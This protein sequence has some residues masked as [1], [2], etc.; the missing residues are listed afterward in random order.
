MRNKIRVGRICWRLRK[1]QHFGAE[2]GVMTKLTRQTVI[3]IVL[4]AAL[5]RICIGSEPIR[6]TRDASDPV[7][8]S[9][10]SPTN[11]LTSLQRSFGT[12]GD[13][14]LVQGDIDFLVPEDGGGACATAA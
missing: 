6:E 9:W 2:E 14:L 10:E 8:R 13:S 7:E 3:G 4:A 1:S 12:D 5:A 11:A